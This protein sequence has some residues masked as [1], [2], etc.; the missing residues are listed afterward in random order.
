MPRIFS[1]FF[2]GTQQRHES[3]FSTAHAEHCVSEVDMSNDQLRPDGRALAAPY[4]LTC[5]N[6]E[7]DLRGT[8]AQGARC[9]MCGL[10]NHL[11]MPPDQDA[12]AAG[13]MATDSRPAPAPAPK[14]GVG[15]MI[16]RV[17][18]GGFWALVTLGLF[19]S[20]MTAVAK[21]HAGGLL[22]LLAAVLTTLYSAY[23]FRGGRFRM[24]FW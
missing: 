7:C 2:N 12:F 10:R 16:S 11:V 9:P 4:D 8:M 3:H 13:Q 19:I 15:D 20:G 18:F 14:I 21:G 5:T 23:I 17:I 1:G 6:E 24:L 22:A